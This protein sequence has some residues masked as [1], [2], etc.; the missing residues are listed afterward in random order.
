MD[1][2]GVA[3][4][5]PLPAE[6]SLRGRDSDIASVLARIKQRYADRITGELTLPA[7]AGCYADFP[8][9][10]D[11][12]LAEALRRRGISRLY[13]HQREAWEAITAGAGTRSS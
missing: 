7:A 10:L 6:S 9:D 2:F 11:P 12:R 1:H 8:A 13:S 3:V 5:H 4:E